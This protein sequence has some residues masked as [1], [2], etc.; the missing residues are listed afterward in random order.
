MPNDTK[1]VELVGLMKEV[2]GI[3]LKLL[4]QQTAPDEYHCSTASGMS[5][6]VSTLHLLLNN[7]PHVLPFMNAGVHSD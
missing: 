1:F 5:M 3:R 2:Q 6:D 4:G 7:A